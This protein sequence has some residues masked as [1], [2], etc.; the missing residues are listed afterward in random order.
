MIRTIIFIT[1]LSLSQLW[2]PAPPQRPVKQEAPAVLDDD[3][4]DPPPPR[5]WD[6]LLQM[7]VPCP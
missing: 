6:E 2:T 4:V 1:L 7:T 3:P 5:C